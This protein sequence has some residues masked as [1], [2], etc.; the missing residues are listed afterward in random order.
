MTLKQPVPG[1][2][3]AEQSQVRPRAQLFADFRRGVSDA[4]SGQKLQVLRG[5]N[6][7][8]QASNGVF[9]SVGINQPALSYTTNGIGLTGL[10]GF[11]YEINRQIRL[12]GQPL[13]PFQVAW[14]G[15]LPT[16]GFSDLNAIWH[17]GDG[18][19]NNRLSL[20]LVGG[21]VSAVY[22]NNAGQ[23]IFSNLS[24]LP[25]QQ[26]IYVVAQMIPSGASDVQIRVAVKKRVAFDDPPWEYGN[27]TGAIECGVAFSTNQMLLHRLSG[28]GT[29]TDAVTYR[30][31]IQNGTADVDDLV[32][33]W[34]ARREGLPGVY[35]LIDDTTV[36]YPELDAPTDLFFQDD[37]S[38]IFINP[39]APSDY[40]LTE[41]GG[42]AS[43]YLTLERIT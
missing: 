21:G 1:R 41:P 19:P 28:L 18:S 43:P 8:A 15:L 31:L 4:I 33:D 5:S 11:E 39:A 9:Y 26:E 24:P 25:L 36:I 29:L 6:T 7:I 38:Y 13:V 30:I 12:A 17:I 16:T 32:W 37:P 23:T 10:G 35:G 2:G 22:V 27:T 14:H 3:R 42:I 34:E 40:L 20:R